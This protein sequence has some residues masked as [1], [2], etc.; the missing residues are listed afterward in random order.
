MK[1]IIFIKT[2][3]KKQI[4]ETITHAEREALYAWLIQDRNEIKARQ[5]IEEVLEEEEDITELQEGLFKSEPEAWEILENKLGLKTTPQIIEK[6]KPVLF[7]RREIWKWAA[8]FTLLLMATW[9]LYKKNVS[10]PAIAET[11]Q[12]I[13]KSTE[14]GQKKTLTLPDGSVVKLNAGSSISFSQPFTNGG[15]RLVSLKGEAFFD[16]KKNKAHPFKVITENMEIKVL[17]TSFNVKAYP[18]DQNEK[19]ALVEGKV[20]AYN[21]EQNENLVFNEI[22]MPDQTLSLNKVNGEVKKIPLQQADIGWK[23]NVI[24]LNEAGFEEIME[25]LS[26]WYGVKFEI[27]KGDRIKIPD[28][29]VGKFENKSL[30]EVLEGLSFSIHFDYEFDNDKK[31][32]YIT[33]SAINENK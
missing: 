16:V 27:E 5:I 2:L 15:T 1:E 22:L 7:F 12:T 18:E 31:I 8:V 11:V 14:L 9:W 32:I 24:Y 10:E 20:S 4:A 26:R 13:I 21:K 23:D 28:R 19:V 6:T 30:M 3:F 33:K 29:Y 25:V 17:G